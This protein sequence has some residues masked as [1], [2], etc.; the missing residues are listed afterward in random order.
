MLKLFVTITG[1]KSNTKT[2][3]AAPN[4][5]DNQEVNDNPTYVQI[6]DSSIK[7]NIANDS[8]VVK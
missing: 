8:S 7:E 6:D 1:N 5:Q 3:I 4:I 2:P